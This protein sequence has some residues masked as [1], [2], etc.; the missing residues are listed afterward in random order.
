MTMVCALAT[1]VQAEITETATDA[2]ANMGLGWNL[3]NTLDAHGAVTKDVTSPAYWGG[4]GVDS[5]TYWGQ[6]ETSV[7]LFGMMKDAGFGAIRVPVTWYN[8]MEQ[9]GTVKHEWMQRV[10]E[11]V[12]YVLDNGL[13]CILNVHHDT[14]ADSG[15]S[16]SWIK[17]DQDIYNNQRER[18]EYLWQQIAEE[19]KDYGEKLLFES[20]NEMLDIKSSWCFASFACPGQYDATIAASAYSGLNGFAQSFVNV[21]RASGGNNA[22]RNLVVNTYAAANGYG[23]WSSHLQEPLTQMN[24]PEDSATGHLIFEVHAY[25]SLANGNQSRSLQEIKNEVNGMITGLNTHLVSK[26]APVIFGEW[27]TSN[28]DSGSGKTDYDVRR[29]LMFQ[30][31]EYFV[32]QTRENGMAT[33]F[34][35]GLSDG[36]YRTMPAFHQ[37]DLAETMAKAYHGSDWQG[38][39][40]EATKMAEIVC[41]EGDKVLGW[42][43]GISINANLFNDFNEDIQLVLNYKQESANGDDIQ[44]FYGDW[45][46]KPKFIVDGTSYMGDFNPSR[47]YGTS[48][49]TEHETV[50]TFD[51]STFQT[52][53]QR[54]L[55]VHGD[56]IRLYKAVL[57]NPNAGIDEVAEDDVPAAM[58][59]LSGRRIATPG[60]GLY[61]QG[62]RK[63]LVCD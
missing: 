36:L 15:N 5:E 51:A 2:V 63:V 23:T 55:I 28:V 42:G 24:L 59:D 33:F 40:P 62:G 21:V 43:N 10:H 38:V 58:Y 29:E 3:G 17:A 26:G 41:F 6:P 22:T 60:S 57:R 35:M 9:D 13:Y 20:Y 56:G 7:S 19:F 18:Y 46:S 34:W 49:G 61:I 31:V 30:F 39:Y 37:A 53:K 4:Q 48:A 54:G 16:C 45:S 11:V 12:D 8:H 50:I 25:P 1:G 47:V 52:V 14:G 32:Q 27:G 44:L